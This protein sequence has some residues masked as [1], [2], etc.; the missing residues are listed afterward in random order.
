MI[1]SFEDLKDDNEN[2]HEKPIKRPGYQWADKVVSKSKQSYS[3]VS[4]THDWYWE[5]T[6]KRKAGVAN[7][8]D[9]AEIKAALK[10][11]RNQWYERVKNNKKLFEPIGS[12]KPYNWDEIIKLPKE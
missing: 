3:R 12:N 4:D 1:R 9:I 6:I 11:V 8:L 10:G 5:E 2:Q 7:A